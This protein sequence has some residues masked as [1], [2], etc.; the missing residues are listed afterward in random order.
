MTTAGINPAIFRVVAQC[1]NHCATACS[2]D[3]A[4]NIYFVM[5]LLHV[6]AFV[7]PIQGSLAQRNV[8]II[9]PVKGV[10]VWS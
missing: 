9:N 8:F 5:L 6:S 4:I 7:G 10:L 3:V 2:E 1:L